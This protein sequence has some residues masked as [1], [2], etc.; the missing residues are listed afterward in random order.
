MRRLRD[1]LLLGALPI[2]FGLLTIL[3]YWSSWPIG[4]DFR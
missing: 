1:P 4:F 2:T 3:G